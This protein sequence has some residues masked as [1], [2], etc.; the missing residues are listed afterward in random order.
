M[1]PGVQLILKPQGNQT[2]N[3]GAGVIMPW[4]ND[5]LGTLPVRGHL[6]H[7]HFW[8][9]RVSAKALLLLGN[10]W[11]VLMRFF[12]PEWWDVIIPIPHAQEA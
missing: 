5:A 6:L 11:V 10:G 4:G 3:A 9:M 1:P 7:H 8:E 12:S 2:R